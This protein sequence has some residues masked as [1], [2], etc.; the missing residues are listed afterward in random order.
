MRLA[1]C[2]AARIA[3]FLLSLSLF[4]RVSSTAFA[5]DPKLD[6]TYT[7][8]S[9]DGIETFFSIPYGKDTSGEH[10]FKPPRPFSPTKGSTIDASSAG[11]ACPQ[12]K[13]DL[14]IPL[15]LSNI[16]EVSED[17]LHLNVYRAQE[18]KAGD[19]LPV[20]LYIHG[21]S[22]YIGSKD[23]LTIQPGGLIVRSA[24]MGI[25]VVFVTINYRLG[26]M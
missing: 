26:G 24:E 20:M 18:T 22:F 19:K 12:P 17:C 13:G 25:P 2:P 6:V 3:G 23:E 4:V 11:P 21:G 1:A 8:V 7:G 16:T 5:R 10:R 15:Y 9:R 14:Y